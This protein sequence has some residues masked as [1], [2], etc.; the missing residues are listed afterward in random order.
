MWA[1]IIYEIVILVLTIALAPKPPT[2]RAAGISDFQLPT[3]DQGRP[4]PVL[5]G[6]CNITGA[7][8]VWYGALNAKPQRTHSLFSSQTTGYQYFLGIHLVLGHGPFDS[9]NS[10]LWDAK[11]TWIGNQTTSGQICMT[12]LSLYGGTPGGQGGIQGCFDIIMGTPSEPVNTYLNAQ[13][14]IVP[15]FKGVVSAVWKTGDI[16]AVFTNADFTQT[17]ITLAGCGYV[18]TTPYVKALEFECTRIAQGWNISGGVWYPAKATVN[19]TQDYSIPPTWTPTFSANT[20]GSTVNTTQTTIPIDVTDTDW[21]L[22]AS[23][24][25]LIGTEWMKVTGVSSGSDGHGGTILTGN[26]NVIRN[27]FGTSPGTYPNNTVF[28]F[29]QADVSNTKAM[30]AAHIVYQCLTDPFWGL[31][32]PITDIDDTQFRTAADTFFAEN[33]GLCMQWVNAQTVQDFLKIVLDHCA[34]NLVMTTA[35]KYRLIPIRGG[36]DVSTL[37]VYD[38]TDILSMDTYQTQA[39]A[40]EVNEVVLTYTDPSTARDTSITAQDL[41]NID[42]QGK[43]VSQTVNYQGI[44]DHILAAAVIGRELNARATPLL[45][46]KFTI[47]RKG[48]G[49]S[50]GGLFVLNWPARNLVGGV[51][52]I[53]QISGGTL[54]GNRIAVD[55]VQDIYSLGLFN[56][57]LSTSIP[58]TQVLTPSQVATAQ[59]PA[60]NSGPTVI[61]ATLTAPPS[62]PLDGDRYVV[63]AG[64]TGVWAGHSGTV[65]V[66]DANIKAW[67]FLPIPPGTAIYD[68]TSGTYVTTN[69]VGAIVPANLGGSMDLIQIQVFGG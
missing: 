69:G 58:P 26:L 11:K 19:H 50:S 36:Y 12:A 4:V 15:S 63:P 10:V 35:G 25:L 49:A 53:T 60:P 23:G 28:Q 47:N 57:Q 7:N 33:M 8:V 31:G 44:R 48:F 38:Q 9:V 61:S 43:T 32:L 20:F 27:V 62:T 13:L 45:T 46:V 34:A 24:F 56:Y 67:V 29:Y 54:Q 5:F 18:G 52:R 51:F 2:P 64:A 21:S 37:P 22:S 14:G 1:S 16:T 17:T 40:D 65:A 41:A 59:A 42:L 6:T 30:N 68:N 3:A 66:W 39:W 55:A